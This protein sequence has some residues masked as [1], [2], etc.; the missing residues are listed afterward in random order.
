[1]TENLG[2]HPKIILYNMISQYSQVC[3][4]TEFCIL[5][6][7]LYLDCGTNKLH[8]FAPDIVLDSFCSILS[9]LVL[10]VSTR[11]RSVFVPIEQELK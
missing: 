11:Y 10:G 1:M 6:K 4:L 5:Q 7:L 8:L 2:F 3:Y 9:N